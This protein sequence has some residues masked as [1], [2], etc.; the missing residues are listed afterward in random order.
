VVGCLSQRGVQIVASNRV[1]CA[2]RASGSR[3]HEHHD[4]SRSAGTS[5]VTAT[6]CRWT[7]SKSNSVEIVGTGR[8][9]AVA[10]YARTTCTRL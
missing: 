1:S 2:R 8:A 10:T 9:W 7:S 4:G 6:S 5:S 3:Q